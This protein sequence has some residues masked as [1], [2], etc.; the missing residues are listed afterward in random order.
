VI[1]QLYDKCFDKLF[2]NLFYLSVI[3]IIITKLLVNGN[4]NELLIFCWQNIV[5]LRKCL[6]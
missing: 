1:N 5:E 2:K 4:I 6:D 3:L